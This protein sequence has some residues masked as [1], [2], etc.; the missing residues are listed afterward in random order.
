MLK[1]LKGASEVKMQKR[2]LMLGKHFVD[3]RV[4]F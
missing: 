1:Q 3:L 4:E 2:V